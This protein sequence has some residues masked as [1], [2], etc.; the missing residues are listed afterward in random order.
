[1]MRR[2]KCIN[3]GCGRDCAPLINKKVLIRYRPYCQ[4]CFNSNRMQ[5]PPREGV[6]AFQKHKCSNKS[7]ILLFD[8]PLDISLLP[9]TKGIFNVD[10]IN[11]NPYDNNPNNIIEWCIICHK[12]K[13][14]KCGDYKSKKSVEEKNY[15]KTI[16]KNIKKFKK[17]LYI[18][19]Q[20]IYINVYERE[21]RKIY[22]RRERV[23]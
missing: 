13:S 22:C 20:S 19:S 6:T 12:I 5:I 15:Y 4:T 17:G 10:H 14:Q 8:C 23:A 16:M 2:P 7:G 21:E 1:M 9:S 11:G 3:P 18:P